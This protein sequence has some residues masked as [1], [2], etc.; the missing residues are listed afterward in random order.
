MQYVLQEHLY[1]QEIM[2]FW[3]YKSYFKAKFKIQGAVKCEL[4]NMPHNSLT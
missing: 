1:L 3:H 4:Q 2:V